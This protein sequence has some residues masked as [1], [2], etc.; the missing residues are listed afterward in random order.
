MK[1]LDRGRR[2]DARQERVDRDGRR[3][4]ERDRGELEARPRVKLPGRDH[5]A[6]EEDGPRG[7][8]GAVLGPRG[9]PREALARARRGV[10][11]ETRSW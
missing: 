3:E 6:Q 1:W 7:R 10:T 11:S 4:L 5:G 9:A 8:E 2:E